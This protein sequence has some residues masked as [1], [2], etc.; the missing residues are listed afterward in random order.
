MAMSRGYADL[1]N[2]GADDGCSW[3]RPA[4]YALL[5]RARCVTAQR[6]GPDVLADECLPFGALA[7]ADLRQTKRRPPVLIRR[8]PD[9]AVPNLPRRDVTIGSTPARAPLRLATA[10]HVLAAMKAIL[11]DCGWR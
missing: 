5:G 6:N 8:S 10:M 2:H 1:R 7:E 11:G 9:R 4:G 3:W